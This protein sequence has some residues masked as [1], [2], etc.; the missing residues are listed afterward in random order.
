MSSNMDVHFSSVKQDWTTPKDFFKYLD[1]EFNFTL[2]AFASEENTLCKNYFTE[3]DNALVQDWSGYTVFM[4]PPYGTM[5]KHCVKKA[6]EESL[7]G[8]RIVMLIPSRTD[9]TYFHDYIYKKSEIRF[10]KG[11]LKF[12]DG[13]NPAPFP[14]MLVIYNNRKE[15]E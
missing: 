13:K 1:Q 3:D 10:L 14:S 5:L 11:R 2:D 12:G 4:N 7:K 8:T 6:Y 15:E 9:T